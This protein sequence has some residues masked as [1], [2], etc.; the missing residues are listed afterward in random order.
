MGCVDYFRRR[1]PQTRIVAVDTLGSVNFE[2][3]S[4]IRYIPGLGTSQRPPLL[5]THG[6]DE[7][8]LIPE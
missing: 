7:V 5:D 8:V 4:S 2:S 3:T 1:S 6:P